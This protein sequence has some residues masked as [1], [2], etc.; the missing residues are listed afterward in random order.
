M[1][2]LSL[3]A[4][5]SEPSKTPFYVIGAVLAAVAVLVSAVGILKPEFPGGESGARGMIAATVLLVAGA[6]VAAALTK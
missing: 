6:M 5:A 2:L 4:E 1:A 3:L